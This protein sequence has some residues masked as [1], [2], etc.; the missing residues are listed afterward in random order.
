[1]TR[2]LSVGSFT[3]FAVQ[4]GKRVVASPL[5][6]LRGVLACHPDPAKTGEGPHIRM[7]ITQITLRD[8]V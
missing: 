8:A 1:M 4:D 5:L 7:L 2:A 6:A 3:V